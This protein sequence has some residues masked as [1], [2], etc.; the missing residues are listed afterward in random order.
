M[1]ELIQ[2]NKRKSVILFLGM[3]FCLLVLGYVIGAAIEPETGGVLG[4]GFAFIIWLILALVSYFS[5]DS[6]LL[7]SSHAH[8]VSRDIH[9]QLFN[10]VEEMKIAANLPAIP[11]IYII[12]EEA[13]NAFAT[14]RNPERSSVAVTAGLLSKLNRDE[15]EGV[16]AH[17]IS[18]VINRDILYMTCAGVLLGSITLLSEVFLRGFFR[19]SV[20]SQRYR[21]RNSSSGRGQ[22]LFIL[23]ALFFAILAPIFAQLFYFALSRKREYL[24]DASGVRLTRYPEGLASALEKISDSKTPLA[25]A[26]K[27][28]APMYIVNP[29]HGEELNFSSLTSTH[30]PILERI[31]ILRSMSQGANYLDYQ[32]AF[33][34]TTGGRTPIIPSSAQKDTESIPFRQPSG[35]RLEAV[36][37]KEKVRGLGDLIRAVNQFSFLTCSCGL[38]FKVPP[39]FEKPAVICPRCFHELRVPIARSGQGESIPMAADRGKE[40]KE[41]ISSSPLEYIRKGNGWETFECACGK[42]LQIS[43]LFQGTHLICE[44]CGRE[45][46]IKNLSPPSVI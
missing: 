23:L 36:E 34:K 39:H 4:L 10:V 44:A 5:G 1:W 8:E 24:A 14:G 38:R 9:P 22:A 17:E 25:S 43:P 18:H 31:R 41:K 7:A 46:E 37:K 2:A 45:T 21:S 3:A 28:T 15:L 42:R 35:G 30:P 13:P 26:N 33:S 40:T 6:I 27:I 20:S 12:D 16:I 29:L 19:T 32:K 11:K